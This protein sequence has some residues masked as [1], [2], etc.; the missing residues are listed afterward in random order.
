M[1]WNCTVDAFPTAS[2]FFLQVHRGRVAYPEKGTSSSGSSKCTI[3]SGSRSRVKGHAVMN[4]FAPRGQT[5]LGKPSVGRA[6]KWRAMRMHNL[7]APGRTNV[8]GRHSRRPSH[9]EWAASWRKIQ[10]KF[11]GLNDGAVLLYLLTSLLWFVLLEKPFLFDSFP[12]YIHD[13]TIEDLS[14]INI[15]SMNEYALTVLMRV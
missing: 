8:R 7:H 11:R 3:M 12:W 1:R 14:Q 5:G 6:L 9:I 2:R 15:L 10:R 13:N 4:C